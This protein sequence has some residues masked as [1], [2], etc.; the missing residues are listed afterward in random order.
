MAQSRAS[1][2]IPSEGTQGPTGI[3]E[4]VVLCAGAGHPATILYRE[5]QKGVLCNK[6][7]KESKLCNLVGWR[8]GRKNELSQPIER[9]IRLLMMA[10]E[11]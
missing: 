6:Q 9:T 10:E 7:R 1:D 8:A 3:G 11:R 2:E 5:K 4:Y